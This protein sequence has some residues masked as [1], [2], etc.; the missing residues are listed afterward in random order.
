MR[1]HAKNWTAVMTRTKLRSA[2]NEVDFRGFG[3]HCARTTDPCVLLGGL[4]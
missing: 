4:P 2:I 3:E 1:S